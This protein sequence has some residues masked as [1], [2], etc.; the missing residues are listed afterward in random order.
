M[1]I[2]LLPNLP[3]FIR[4]VCSG[5]TPWWGVKGN[6]MVSNVPTAMEPSKEKRG[7]RRAGVCD[8]SVTP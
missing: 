4:R 7:F 1:S 6:A 2:E 8:Y 3:S 5:Y